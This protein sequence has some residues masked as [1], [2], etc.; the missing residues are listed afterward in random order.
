M[1]GSPLDDT[2]IRKRTDRFLAA[3]EQVRKEL[4]A[5]LCADLSDENVR[6]VSA[7]L[8]QRRDTESLYWLVE[9]L[10]QVQTESA[11][12]KLMQMLGSENEVA[13]LQARAGLEKVDPDLQLRFL[14]SL[15]SSNEPDKILFAAPRLGQL[16]FKKAVPDLMTVLK[17]TQDEESSAVIL[18][19]LGKL[20]DPR[21]IPLLESFAFQ[22]SPETQEQ[23]LA[24]L[25]L[26]RPELPARF[27]L[28]SLKAQNT[29]TRR[30]AYRAL[31]KQQNTRW[32]RVLAE[33]LPGEKNDA[34]LHEILSSVRS[35][36]RPELFKVIQR[37]AVES[38]SRE[39]VM[40]AT[41]LLTRLKTPQMLEWLRE[42]L[43]SDS[44]ALK[45]LNIRLLGTPSFLRSCASDILELYRSEPDPKIRLTV[46]ASFE[47]CDLPVVREFLWS[48]ALA[49]GPFS[50]AAASA[51][52]EALNPGEWPRIEACFDAQSPAS[53]ALRRI[54]LSALCRIS[55]PGSI[56]DKLQAA[57][58]NLLSSPDPRLRYDAV[59][60]YGRFS[61]SNKIQRLLVLSAR[62]TETM[63]RKAAYDELRAILTR[64]PEKLSEILSTCFSVR[65]L[66]RVASRLF[67]DISARDLAT[68]RT[69]LSE[70]FE[71]IRKY[72]GFP[73]K[74]M[75]IARLHV[76]IRNLALKERSLFVSAVALP[77]WTPEQKGL[78]IRAMNKIRLFEMEGLS[79]DFP[80][81]EYAG[82]APDIKKEILLFISRRTVCGEGLKSALYRAFETETIPEIRDLLEEVIAG[83]I[84]V[85]M[86]APSP[87]P[88]AVL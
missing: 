65:E 62:D 25:F 31:L 78:L 24:A 60:A 57:I 7:A 55:N 3:D 21:A 52:P 83:W 35:I 67:R 69:L 43:R 1:A 28:K 36:R 34:L 32:E 70:I 6:H 77:E 71:M 46:L 59:R 73:R 27:I 19:A 15:L 84:R 41:S 51:L 47:G 16:G 88:R 61:A 2:L 56:P 9:F 4:F 18:K 20:R 44:P 30:F 40:R 66:F 23:A 68:T 29:R 10:V 58:Q 42:G 5:S 63:V 14:I 26:L 76:L 50:M 87:G 86:L 80:K 17:Q 11:L 38:P 39:T 82:A 22:G 85:S 33:K 54:L 79:E 48:T 81:D 37:L 12:E 53:A 64:S 74:P 49:G 75:P 45:I 8:S 72:E 13:R